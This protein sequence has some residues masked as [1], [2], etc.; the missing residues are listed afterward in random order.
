[1]GRIKDIANNLAEKYR[2]RNPYEL[3]DFLNIPILYNPLGNIKG[4]F[5]NVSGTPIIHLNNTLSEDELKP[6]IAH[7]LGHA[8]LHKEFNVCFLNNYTFSITDKYE[9]EANK[10]AAHLLIDDKDLNTFSSGYEYVTIEQLSKHF[11]VPEEFIMYKMR[12]KFQ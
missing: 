12:G 5:Q 11:C 3:C 7:E 10:F 1:M 8:L 2:T 4:L 6:V 9:N